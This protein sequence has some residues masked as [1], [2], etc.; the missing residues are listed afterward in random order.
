MRY[1]P[2]DD[3]SA[4]LDSLGGTS[5]REGLEQLLRAN[6][7]QEL[8][9]LVPNVAHGFIY[10]EDLPPGGHIEGLGNHFIDQ[11]GRIGLIE[12]ARS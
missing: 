1:A 3:E 12:L 8:G 2:G 11:A 10:L 4:V 5:D 9:S 6:R 7:L